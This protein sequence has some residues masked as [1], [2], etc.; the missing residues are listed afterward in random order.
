MGNSLRVAIIDDK[1]IVENLQEYYE[2]LFEP[3]GYQ[4]DFLLFSDQN[5]L[6][7]H[8]RRNVTHVV[9]CDL[10]LG[11]MENLN[12]LLLI[13][14]IKNNWPQIVCIGSTKAPVS[15]RQTTSKS[16]SFDLFI[17]K[18]KLFGNDGVYYNEI[19]K[20]LYNL[21]K[22][23]IYINVSRKSKLLKL[24]KSIDDINL[25]SILSQITFTGHPNSDF[26]K[27]DEVELSPLSGGRSGSDVYRIKAFSS[28]TTVH[29]VPAVLKISEINKA[30]IELEN[31]HRFVKWTLPYTWRVDLLGTGFTKNLGGICYSFILSGLHDFD[32]FTFFIQNKYDDVISD[33]ISQVFSPQMKTWYNS[34]IECENI[35]QRY[36]SKYFWGTMNNESNNFSKYVQK[37]YNGIIGSGNVSIFDRKF[38]TPFEELF[39]EPKGKYNSCICHGDLNSNNIIASKN[40]EF[41]FIDFQDTGRGH[42]FEDF[43]TLES[44]I[45]INYPIEDNI[46]P[47]T[48]LN[49]EILLSTKGKVESSNIKLY[50][51]ISKIRKLAF[52]NF[53]MEPKKNYFFG[54]AAFNFRLLRIESLSAMQKI[55]VV[56]VIL[57][58]LRYNVLSRNSLPSKPTF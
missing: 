19:Y 52:E 28:A 22:T 46:T 23:N 43:I 10:S 54:V 16:P 9:I 50:D 31:Y 57:A 42:V 32:S 13:Q 35:N 39:G 41:I 21:L 8:L 51:H 33:V 15:Y 34:V 17:D 27:I 1:D 26:V 56:G 6:L 48:I 37:Y 36:S 29:T 5:K 30:N 18:G 40:K 7:N 53:P 38:P 20:L 11:D 12:G 47:E 24:F 45:R 58:N 44:S 2:K 55:L 3:L 4:C 14:T 25:Q 49:N